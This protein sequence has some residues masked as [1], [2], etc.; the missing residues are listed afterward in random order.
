MQ[1]FSEMEENKRQSRALNLQAMLNFAEL[2]QRERELGLR[3]QDL[4]EE[5][6][7]RR[8]Q[9]APE[10]E[11]RQMQ[12]KRAREAESF[13]QEIGG[14]IPPPPPLPPNL[15]ES[16]EFGP[17]VRDIA[18]GAVLHTLLRRVQEKPGA[19]LRHPEVVRSVLDFVMLPEQIEKQRATDV[20]QFRKGEVDI[21]R[22]RQDI[23]ES[24]AKTEAF[25]SARA[26]GGLIGSAFQKLSRLQAEGGTPEQ[27]SEVLSELHGAF[28]K[29][30]IESDRATAMAFEIGEKI[31]SPDELKI[32]REA[33]RRAA[34]GA[35]AG[36]EQEAASTAEELIKTTENALDLLRPAEFK[37]DRAVTHLKQVIKANE[38]TIN[39]AATSTGK[40]VD[41]RAKKMAM[42]K[43]IEAAWLKL[44][45]RNVVV[46]EKG[47]PVR[48]KE[49]KE[50]G[51]QDLIHR[52]GDLEFL[53]EVWDTYS[54]NAQ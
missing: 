8:E 49:V 46:D 35:E 39:L 9:A 23:E 42:W 40:R 31:K 53:Q 41:E 2:Q 15:T 6:A 18:N 26:G 16:E 7:F 48:L 14:M 29:S 44:M 11:L 36:R 38:E 54:P 28:V 50:G 45:K 21:E 3:R 4:A 20:Q 12:L 47:R 43:S 27:K 13:E 10:M 19:A 24:R 33:S 52:V 32:E 17:A 22:G 25:R 5:R 34:A 30:G 1:I 51:G 37:Q